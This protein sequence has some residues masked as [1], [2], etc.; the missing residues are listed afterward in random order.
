MWQV[1]YQEHW[2][3]HFTML[4]HSNQRD[5]IFA[6]EIQFLQGSAPAHCD[7]ELRSQAENLGASASIIWEH[8]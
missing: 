8:I 4:S 2:I 6:S 3:V 7:L 1:D 5:P